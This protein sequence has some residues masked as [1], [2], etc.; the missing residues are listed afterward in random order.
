MTKQ[1]DDFRKKCGNLLQ[2]K[3]CNITSID[4]KQKDGMTGSRFWQP[5]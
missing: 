3:I 4:T 2:I 5:I 1:K